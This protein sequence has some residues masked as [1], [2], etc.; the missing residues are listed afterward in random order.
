MRQS[1]TVD[2]RCEWLLMQ[3]EMGIRYFAQVPATWGGCVFPVVTELFP[4]RCEKIFD[5]VGASA[6]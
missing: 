6:G 2:S 4:E 3:N 5:A 1:T